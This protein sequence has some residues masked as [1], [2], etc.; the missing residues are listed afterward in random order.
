[1]IVELGEG[2][3]RRTVIGRVDDGYDAY[4]CVAG[5]QWFGA[6]LQQSGGNTGEDE[7]ALVCCVVSG[8]FF[9]EEFQLGKRAQLLGLF[10]EYAELVTKFTREE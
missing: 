3:E 5:G 9:F 10:S 4:H 6:E 2:G 1:M 8:G 7:W